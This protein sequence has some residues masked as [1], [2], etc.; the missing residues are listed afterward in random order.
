MAALSLSSVS[1]VAMTEVEFFFKYN[2][3]NDTCVGGPGEHEH[4]HVDDGHLER[5]HQT[6]LLVLVVPVLVK[7]ERLVR[8]QV[9]GASES[10]KQIK[11]MKS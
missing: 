1:Q 9:G 8:Q 3:L 2:Y 6:L 11:N 10:D 4:H 7:V 5:L